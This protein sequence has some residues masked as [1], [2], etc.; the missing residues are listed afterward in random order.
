MVGYVSNHYG[1]D[2]A[3][4]MTTNPHSHQIVLRIKQEYVTRLDEEENR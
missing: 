4:T 2:Y 3:Y 1:S